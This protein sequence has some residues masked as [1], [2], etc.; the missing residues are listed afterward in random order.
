M[1]RCQDQS[2]RWSEVKTPSPKRG[3]KASLK[4]GDFPHFGKPEVRMCLASRCDRVVT[5]SIP[6]ARVRMTW[7][8]AGWC[9][10]SWW[11]S[12]GVPFESERKRS[13]TIESPKGSP[14]G[15]SGARR[16]WR[17]EARW[18]NWESRIRSRI[19]RVRE[20][21]MMKSINRV[22]QFEDGVRRVMRAVSRMDDARKYGFMLKMRKL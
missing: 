12:L 17:A 1:A 2:P 15:V 19:W 11:R 14:E 22:N 8:W 4:W 7:V 9:R 20:M 5:I 13:K 6:R 18:F 10:K 16:A 3:W 21:R